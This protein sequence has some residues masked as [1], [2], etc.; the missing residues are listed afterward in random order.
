MVSHLELQEADSAADA[1]GL[2]HTGG[3]CQDMQLL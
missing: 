1:C 2:A 3:S